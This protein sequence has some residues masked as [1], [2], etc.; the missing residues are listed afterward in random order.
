MSNKTQKYKNSTF[1]IVFIVLSI[2]MVLPFW[3]S[4]RIVIFSDFSFHASRVEEIANNLSK[5]QFF[6][7]IATKTFHHTGVAS[8]LFY[9]TIFLYPWAIFSLFLNPI[10]A[11][12]LWYLIFTIITFYISY[13]C[14]LAFSDNKMQSFIFS[15]LYTVVPYRLYLGTSVFGE[16]IAY[17]FLPIVFLGIYNIFWGKNDGLKWTILSIGMA[18]VGYSHVLSVVLCCEFLLIITIFA[19]VT[20][21]F[22]KARIISLIKSIVLTFLLVIF[23]II[24]FLQSFKKIYSPNQ[25]IGIETKFT[26]FISYSLENLES[27]CSIGFILLLTLF[28]GIVFVDS[29]KYKFIYLLGVIACFFATSLFPWKIFEHSPLAVIQL[30]FRYLAYASLFLSVVSSKILLKVVKNRNTIGLIASLSLFVILF[31][32]FAQQAN[33]QLLRNFSSKDMI[34]KSTTTPVQSLPLQTV[35]NNYTYNKIFNYSVVFGEQDYYPIKAIENPKNL[36][37]K[38]ILSIMNNVTIINGQKKYYHPLFLPNRIVFKL[39]LKNNVQVDLPVLQY[40][41]TF[42]KVNNKLVKYTQSSRGTVLI[43]LKKGN[44]IVEVGYRPWKLYYLTLFISAI[45]WIGLLY[46]YIKMHNKTLDNR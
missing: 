14:M 23:E 21:R 37:D 11:F 24:P 7:F 18:L 10:N 39:K 3:L 22:N 8:F 17:S 34:A 12:Y 36:N 30:T 32:A 5:G 41:G 25:G 27:N 6:T 26:Q 2:M 46:E 29:K 19:L 16:F 45:A 42:V 15:L 4:H 28:V 20:R 33:L 1:F 44:N 40:N 43:N 35:V 38:K 9:P 13:L 31:S